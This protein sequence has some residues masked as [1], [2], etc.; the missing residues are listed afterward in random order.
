MSPQTIAGRKPP[1]PLLGK[2][3]PRLLIPCVAVCS[4]AVPE[5]ASYPSQAG[6]WLGY[7]PQ[8]YEP[9]RTQFRQSCA[10]ILARERGFCRSYR[11]ARPTDPA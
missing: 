5:A 11:I 2:L 8:S 10:E 7:F 3:L 6:Q 4:A 9:S 1:H